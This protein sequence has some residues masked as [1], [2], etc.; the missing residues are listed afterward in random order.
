M[1]RVPFESL[2]DSA[3]VWVFASERPIH[4]E[5]S[6]PLLREV[7]S[8]LEQWKAH[9]APLAASRDWREHRFLTIAVDESA[10]GA[11][12]CSIDGLFRVLKRMEPAV[13]SSLTGKGMV[14]FRDAAGGVSSASRDLFG[15]LAAAGAVGPRTRVFDTAVS[16]LA[17]WRQRFETEVAGSWHAKLIPGA[18]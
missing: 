7:D 12:G 14:Y 2:P 17:E 9:G 18:V 5:D 8:F 1:P 15:E 3:R 16:T 11:S 4:D 13:R 6:E 10:T